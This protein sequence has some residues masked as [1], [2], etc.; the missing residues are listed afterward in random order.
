MSHESPIN[1]ELEGFKDGRQ[2]TNSEILAFVGFLNDEKNDGALRN[3]TSKFMAP[4]LKKASDFMTEKFPQRSWRSDTTL[5]SQ[6]KRIRGDWRIFKDILDRNRGQRNSQ[7]S[8]TRSRVTLSYAQ[9]LY[10]ARLRT[11]DAYHPL[12]SRAWDADTS[13]RR[14]ISRRIIRAPAGHNSDRFKVVSPT[15]GL[16][17]EDAAAALL[18]TGEPTRPG[19]RSIVTGRKD[20]VTTLAL[21]T[22]CTET[23]QSSPLAKGGWPDPKFTMG[24]SGVRL[25]AYKPPSSSPPPA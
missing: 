11:L 3:T 7:R 18:A 20:L 21:G 17:K 8:F 10:S 16:S 25:L 22:L 12:T 13:V 19:R 4:I 1:N 14:A 23:V 5:R 6:F 2:W 24:R 15:N 9:L